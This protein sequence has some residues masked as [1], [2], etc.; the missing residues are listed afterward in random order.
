M[1]RL[2]FGCVVLAL[3]LVPSSARAEWQIKPFAGLTFGGDTTFV[4]WDQAAGSRK[5]VIGASALWEGNVLGLEADLG[6]TPDFFTGDGGRDDLDLILSSRV[7]TLT[8]NVVVAVPRQIARYTLRP[9]FVIGAGLMQ[10]AFDDALAALP[11]SKSLPTL[12]VG[13]GATGML[14]DSIGLNWDVRY[15][16]SLKP[17]VGTLAESLGQPPRLSFWRAT[18]GLTIRP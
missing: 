10:V 12:D 15:F 14:T 5:T 1:R 13:G 6:H 8:G 2:L 3:V 11:V 9:Y 18:M 16:R 17:G 7:T 4:D